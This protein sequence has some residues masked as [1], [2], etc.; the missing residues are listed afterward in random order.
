MYN[1]AVSS[2]FVILI[3]LL[4]SNDCIRNSKDVRC[5]LWVLIK[6]NNDIVTELAYTDNYRTLWGKQYTTF[7]YYT[8]I[9]NFTNDR[10]CVGFFLN[11][12]AT[13]CMGMRIIRVLRCKSWADKY[14]IHRALARLIHITHLSQRTD[15]Y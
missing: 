6:F 14:E 10:I 11:V 12:P 3:Y 7:K 15:C 5:Y 2:T 8:H 9:V 4:L 1:Y 13:K